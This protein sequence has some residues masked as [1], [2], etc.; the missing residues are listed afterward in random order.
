MVMT[1]EK[2]I[3]QMHRCIT[4]DCVLCEYS[5]DHGCKDHVM[6]AAMDMLER[7]GR[8]I[9]Q[10]E[11]RLTVKP[12]PEGELPDDLMDRMTITLS[13]EELKDLLKEEKTK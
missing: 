8:Q 12:K 1:R 13:I 4:Y 7:D 11:A 9:S 2:L 3:D 6:K 10:M 5:S